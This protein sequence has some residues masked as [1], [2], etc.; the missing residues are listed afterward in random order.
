[1]DI[2]NPEINFRPRAAALLFFAR[3]K[4]NA[5]GAGLMRFLENAPER[6]PDP[7]DELS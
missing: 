5:T 7:G 6:P 3:R 1:L 4:G 2:K